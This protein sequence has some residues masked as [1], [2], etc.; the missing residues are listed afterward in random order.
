MAK[1]SKRSNK[2]ISMEKKLEKKLKA[3]FGE[4]IGN[5]KITQMNVAD[6]ALE[7]SQ[8]FGANKNLYRTIASI[9]DGLA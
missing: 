9:I 4:R 8:L 3:E 1:K 2:D 7:Y 5:E 6:A